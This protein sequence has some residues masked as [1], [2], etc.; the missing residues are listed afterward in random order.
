MVM[1]VLFIWRIYDPPAGLR[2]LCVRVGKLGID[3]L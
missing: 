3:L 2:E 1:L